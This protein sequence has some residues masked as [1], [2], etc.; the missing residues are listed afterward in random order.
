MKHY[1]LLL[2]ILFQI[3]VL[4]T[5]S[6]Y[7]VPDP[8][9]RASF[10]IKNID[11]QINQKIQWISPSLE[12]KEI[13]LVDN[14]FTLP[15]NKE[16]FYHLFLLNYTQ[17]N[18]HYSA[19]YFYKKFGKPSSISP[20]EVS[21]FYQNG[22]EFIPL[23]LPME[24]DRY[25]SSNSYKFKLLFDNK[26]LENTLVY[27][28]TLNG[29][30]QEYFTNHKGECIIQ[31]PNDFE[32][33]KK[34]LRANKPSYFIV[35]ATLQK[36]NNNYFT[37]LTQPYYLNPTDHWRSIPYGFILIVVGLVLGIFIYKRFKNG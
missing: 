30:K 27:F 37:T 4:G 21:S 18:N 7:I 13:D 25:Y 2:S 23:P 11:T 24:H 15:K 35:T 5:S 14:K 8:T 20:K 16:A 34:G 22:F 28:T 19:K 33:V 10:E 12:K 26:E 31:L 36:D 9:S 32:N 17:Q 29:S 3:N 6:L 1:I